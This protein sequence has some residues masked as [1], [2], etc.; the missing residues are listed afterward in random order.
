MPYT[1][2][3]NRIAKRRNWTLLDMTRSMMSSLEMSIQ[4]L[5]E[6]LSKATYILNKVFTKANL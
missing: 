1:L 4:F 2:Q 6:A 3:Q 5:G